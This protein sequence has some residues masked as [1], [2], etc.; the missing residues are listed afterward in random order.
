MPVLR[1]V[2]RV[3]EDVWRLVEALTLAFV[4]L[5]GALVR[6]DTLRDGALNFDNLGKSIDK[7]ADF[8]VRFV[9]AVTSAVEMVTDLFDA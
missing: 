7:A 8:M 5:M 3:G 1:D 9:D 6:D 4:H 2:E